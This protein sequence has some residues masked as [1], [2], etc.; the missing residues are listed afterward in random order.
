MDGTSWGIDRN[1]ESKVSFGY[2]KG[3]TTALEFTRRLLGEG[4]GQKLA[5]LLSTPLADAEIAMVTGSSDN[6]WIKGYR[7]GYNL[8]IVNLLHAAKCYGRTKCSGLRSLETEL[9]K[10]EKTFADVVR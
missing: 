5:K 6:R 7:F 9:E 4:D 3:F 10:F 2:E 1:G 8:T